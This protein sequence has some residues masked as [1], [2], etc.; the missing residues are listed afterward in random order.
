MEHLLTF[1]HQLEQTAKLLLKSK[2]ALFFG[3]CAVILFSATTGFASFFARLPST[4]H[5]EELG[6]VST[7]ILDKNGK[8]L[9]EIHGEVKRTPVTLDNI[10]PYLINATMAIEDKNF[11]SHPGVSA[12]SIARAAYA[13][14]KGGSITQGGSTITQQLAKN[15]LLTRQRSFKRKINEAM[16]AIIIEAR[17]SKDEILEMYLNSTPYGRNTYGVEAASLSYFHKHSKDLTLSESAYLASLPKA[18]S[19]LSPFGPKTEE[20]EG[21]KNYVLTVMKE[22]KLLSEDEYRQAKKEKTTFRPGKTGIQAPHFVK[23]LEQNLEKQFGRKYLEEEGLLVYTTLDLDLQTQAEAIV[24]E[25]VSKNE[26]KYKAFNA[27]LVAM[28]TG[29]GQILAMVGGKDY[30]ADPL[31]EGC[32]PGINCL[33]DPKVNVALALRQP[34]SSFKPYVYAT[35]FN[36]ENKLSPAS[37]VLDK[38]KNFSKPGFT[39]YIPSNY[40]NQEYGPVTIRKALAGSLNISAVRTLERVGV[41]NAAETARNF[42]ITSPLN[43]CGLSLALGACEVT[44]LDHLSGFTVLANNGKRIK[45]SLVTKIEDKRGN[46]LFE[47][48][49]EEKQVI[50]PQAAYEVVSILSDNDARSFI[51]GKN[52]P[53]TLKDRPVAAKTG[54]SQ[55]FKDGWTLGFTPQ[56]AVGVWVGN[57][58]GTLMKQKADG[59]FVAGPIWHAFMEIAHKDKP[60]VEFTKPEGLREIRISKSSGKLATQHTIDPIK[61]LVADYAVPTQYDPYVPPPP[62]ETIELAVGGVDQVGETGKPDNLS[63]APN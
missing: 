18:P 16:L 35:A 11:R 40:N 37:T 33:F 10:S 6:P 29:T 56:I 58:N 46:V 42:G 12:T 52:S 57:N 1:G 32:K 30:F 51:F 31:P 24:E 5:L 23:W 54:T 9:Y 60:V 41:D 48:K 8:L 3:I 49:M 4:G 34:G 50:Q 14:I 15:L 25:A 21:R 17:Y 47:H 22:Q 27:G 20:L 26:K 55:D 63:V 62:Q 59:V 28:D 19:R 36:S 2:K 61:I 7:K 53:L 45:P 13:N 44:L 38:K 43:N 39:P